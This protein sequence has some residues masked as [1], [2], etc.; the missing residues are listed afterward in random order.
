[1]PAPL[2]LPGSPVWIDLLTS[3][4]E[5]ALVFYGRLF[6]WT[7]S[8]LGPDFDGYVRWKKHD[9]PVAGM[10]ANSSPAPDAWTVYLETDDTERT[11][12]RV[13]AEAG[14]IFLQKRLGDL[15][16][17][18]LLGDNTGAMLGAWQPETFP[19]FGV[20][21]ESDTPVWHELHTSDYPAALA[22]YRDVFDWESE[23][24]GDGDD[25]RMST[26]GAG[27]SA[28]AGIFDASRELGDGEASHWLIYFGTVDADASAERVV[29]LGG[30]LTAP[31]ENTEYGRL[32]FAADPTGASF[33]LL[34]E[35]V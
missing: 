9:L 29:Q 2:V 3:D 26:L 23:S 30:S 22:F 15:G 27:D 21:S 10:T 31:V 1:M 7:A 32:V 20:V 14:S 25:F 24:I 28:V 16:E 5:Q 35:P 6:G 11:A 19:G 13:K 8:E 4:P 34:Q 17:M 33:A 12:A 18:L